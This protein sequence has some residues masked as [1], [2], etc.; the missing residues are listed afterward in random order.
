MINETTQA[1]ILCVLGLAGGIYVDADTAQALNSIPIDGTTVTGGGVGLAVALISRGLFKRID[2]LIGML[3]QAA[4]A[5]NAHVQRTENIHRAVL[6][7]IRERPG[8]PS[9]IDDPDTAP[10]SISEGLIK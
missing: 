1:T 3:R 7:E 6:A 9:P 2:D 10:I 8:A 5:W 4:N